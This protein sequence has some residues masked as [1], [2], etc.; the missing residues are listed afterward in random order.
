M[1]RGALPPRLIRNIVNRWPPTFLTIRTR[2]KKS[3]RFERPRSTKRS[4]RLSPRAI[5]LPRTRIPITTTRQSRNDPALTRESR[6]E[7]DHR[8]CHDARLLA[9]V[10]RGSDDPIVALEPHAEP[11]SQAQIDSAPGLIRKIGDGI[12]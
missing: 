5:R 7:T 8:R 4:R 12:A 11:P 9:V 1:R 3:E 2:R 10:A 6:S